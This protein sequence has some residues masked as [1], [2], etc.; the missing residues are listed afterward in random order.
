[1]AGGKSSKPELW[2]ACG[3]Q[4]PTEDRPTR[5]GHPHPFLIC[6]AVQ[7]PAPA[8]FCE[9]GGQAFEETTQLAKIGFVW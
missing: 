1:M 6:P 8:V 7:L 4:G 3:L 2:A 9:E 5:A